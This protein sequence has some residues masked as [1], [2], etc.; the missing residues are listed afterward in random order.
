[1]T[2]KPAE[3]HDRPRPT[4]TPRFW[5]TPAVGS[6]RRGRPLKR[7]TVRRKGQRHHGAL[8]EQRAAQ[9]VRMLL[10]S[11]ILLLLG[12]LLILTLRLGQHLWPAWVVDQR[13]PIIGFLGLISMV[14]IAGF[15]FIVELAIN[16]RGVSGPGDLPSSWG[17]PPRWP[18]R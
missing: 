3:R 2:R 16:F 8:D 12:A 17:A 6:A 7:R 1:M 14:L 13:T 5:N 9:S 15:P 18:R 4:S 10:G 11:V